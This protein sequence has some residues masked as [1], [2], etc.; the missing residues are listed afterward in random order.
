MA[1]RSWRSDLG[2][3]VAVSPMNVI[4]DAF[5]S[6]AGIEQVFVCQ[7]GDARLSVLIV[8]NEKN[9]DSKKQI[10][11]REA[12]IIDVLAGIQVSFDVLVRDNRPLRQLISPR[13]NLLFSRV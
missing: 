12:E 9:Y 3:A 1:T 6:L 10:F 13:G 5:S 7:E 2:T 4:R 11:D 8:V